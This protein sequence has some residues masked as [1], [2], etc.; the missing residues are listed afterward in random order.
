MRSA[1]ARLDRARLP[2][3]GLYAEP[4]RWGNTPGLAVVGARVGALDKHGAQH[5]DAGPGAPG[6]A[7]AGALVVAGAQAGPGGEAPGVAEHARVGSDLAQDGASRRVVATGDGLQ[8]AERLGVGRER[9]VELPVELLRAPADGG[10]FARQVRRA[11]CDPSRVVPS[12]GR[13]RVDRVGAD[14]GVGEARMSVLSSRS[15][16]PSRMRRPFL[17][18]MS[19][20]NAPMRTPRRS[21]TFCAW[22]RRAN[23]FRRMAAPGSQVAELLGGNE[24][25]PPGHELAH[26]RQAAVLDIGL[27]CGAI[28]QQ[29]PPEPRIS[30]FGVVTRRVAMTVW[31]ESAGSREEVGS[32]GRQGSSH[33]RA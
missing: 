11:G 4:C 8:Q 21:I 6:A 29:R 26:Q 16:K 32:E 7:F 12:L 9:L 19:V 31:I 2:K 3:N 22:L 5:L 24:A 30:C 25:R 10:V 17:P 23:S 15:T 18:R 14:V 1:V 28:A 13:R 27:P 20:S 33:C